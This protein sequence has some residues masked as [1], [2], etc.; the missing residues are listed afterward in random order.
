[1][2]PAWLQSRTLFRVVKQAR[3]KAGQHTPTKNCWT[4]LR[5]S[6]NILIEKQVYS[7]LE[8]AV[9][10]AQKEFVLTLRYFLFQKLLT[11]PQPYQEGVRYGLDQT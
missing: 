10:A 11:G 3:A 4:F 6:S 7:V 1:M 2:S 5:L 9:H 8:R